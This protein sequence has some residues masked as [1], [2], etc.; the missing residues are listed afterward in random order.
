MQLRRNSYNFVKSVMFLT[1][2]RDPKNYIIISANNNVISAFENNGFHTNVI[3]PI[4]DENK[5]MLDGE[6]I[7]ELKYRK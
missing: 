3:Y 1:K 7:K 2:C 6:D 4:D 5:V